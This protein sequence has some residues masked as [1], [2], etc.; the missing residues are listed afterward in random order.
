MSAQFVIC[1]ILS[2]CTI[3]KNVFLKV[4]LNFQNFHAT[5]NFLEAYLQSGMKCTTYVQ[6]D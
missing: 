4:W 5:G 1:V 2:M 3:L 6:L